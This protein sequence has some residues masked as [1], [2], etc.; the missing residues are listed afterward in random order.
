MCQTTDGV[1]DAGGKLKSPASGVIP[2]AESI[3]DGFTTD[4]PDTID[5]RADTATIT[6]NLDK[7][8]HES[9]QYY[10]ECSKRQ[11]NGG[12]FLADQK[13]NGRTAQFTRQNNNG[14]RR[15]LEW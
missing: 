15:G 6:S 9:E 4:R 11:R 10:F 1:Q 7:G 14:N 12:L 5:N 8:H 3:R 13:L 2:G